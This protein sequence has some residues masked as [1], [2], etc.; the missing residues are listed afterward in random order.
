MTDLE[1][2]PLLSQI[3]TSFIDGVSGPDLQSLLDKL[4]ERR[5]LSDAEREAAEERSRRDK[6]RFV[7]DT[8]RRKGEADSSEMIRFLSEHLGLM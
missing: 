5:V 1:S 7:I 4:M 3:R 6:A 2:T 8:V